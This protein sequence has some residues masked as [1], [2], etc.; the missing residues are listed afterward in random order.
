[1]IISSKNNITDYVFD[2]A[3]TNPEKPALLY[4]QKITYSEFCKT[5]EIFAFS[6]RKLG[7][8][9]GTKTIVLVKPGVDLFAIT[10]ALFRIGAVPVLIDPGMGNRAMANALAKTEAEAFVGI[11]K[12]HLLKYIYPKAFQTVKIWISTKFCGLRHC[13]NLRNFKNNN[14][15]KNEVQFVQDNDLAA[16]FFTS[17][18]TGPAKGVL[19]RNYMLDAQIRFLKNHFRYRSDDIDLCTFPLIGLMLLCHGLSIVLADMDMTRPIK[20]KP[21]K[22]INN[23][24]RFCCTHMFC[25][26]MVL[27]RLAKYGIENNSKLPTLKK[28]MTAGAPVS[29]E[30]LQNF[31]KLLSDDSEIHTPYGATEALPVTDICDT[32]LLQL[33]KTRK[34]YSDGICIGYPLEEIDLQIIPITDKPV[35]VLSVLKSE[36]IGEIIIRGPNVTQEYLADESVNQISKIK[37]DNSEW[38]WHRTGDLGRLDEKGRVWFLGRKTQR[39]ETEKYCLYTIPCE[40]V[41]NQHPKVMRSALVGVRLENKQFDEPLICIE[42]EKGEKESESLRKELLKLAQKVSITKSIKTIL[43]HKK[44]PVDARHNAKIFREKLALWAQ[45]Q[46]Q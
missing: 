28:N 34:N 11:P 6:F 23:I 24:N 7:I 3:K 36:E 40:A 16:I 43:F 35:W 38:L 8:L 2:F 44:F 19:Y 45:K 15:Q 46:I 42:L 22:L 29:P 31:R 25:S 20:L 13:Y 39:I 33:Y 27:T 41:F 5:V 30:L 4:P 10:F 17:G 26:P 18:S 37:D 12:A 32:E 9:K 21:K 14:N 1:M